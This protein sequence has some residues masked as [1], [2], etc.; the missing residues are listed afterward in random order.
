MQLNMNIAPA[1]E[2]DISFS[3]PSKVEIFWHSFMSRTLLASFYEDYFN[4]IPFKGNET[5]LDFGCGWGTEAKIMAKKLNKGGRL[6][7]LDISPEWIAETKVVLKDF[8]NIDYYLGDI[9]TLNI[10]ENSFDIIVVHIV[11]HDIDLDL[12]QA[13]IDSLARTLK[14][15]GKLYI[16]EP[17]MSE[18]Q[19]SAVSIESLM[20]NAKLYKTTIKFSNSIVMGKIIEMVFEKK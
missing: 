4:Q 9:T 3:K 13:I 16:R 14:K 5:V 10:P 17:L 12:R 8:K 20:N 11:L 6:A 19:I 7:C 18:R 15:D 1:Q 2:S